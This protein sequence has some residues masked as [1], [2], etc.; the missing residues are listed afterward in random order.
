MRGDYSYYTID[1]ETDSIGGG[2]IIGGLYDLKNK[3][4]IYYDNEQEYWD[5]IIEL[6]LKRVKIFGHY[7]GRYDYQYLVNYLIKYRKDVKF[8]IIYNSK[9]IFIKMNN[10]FLYDTYNVFLTSLAKLEKAFNIERL[11]S[12]ETAKKMS[13]DYYKENKEQVI[14]YL[15]EDCINLANIILKFEE[16]VGSKIKATI[17]SQAMSYYYEHYKQIL[18]SSDTPTKQFLRKGYFG[19]RT[20]VFKRYGKNLFYYDINSSYPYIMRNFQMPVGGAMIV[21]EYID[22]AIGFYDI[23]VTNYNVKLPYIA[24]KY[25]NKLIYPL[26]TFQAYVTNLEI[27]ELIKD[28]QDFKVVRGIVYRHIKNIFRDY[29]DYF[30]QMKQ[31]AKA[32]DNKILYLISKL[33]MNSLYGKFAER[34][35]KEVIKNLKFEEVKKLLEKEIKVKSF[36]S[37]LG[38]YAVEEVIKSD[39]IHIQISSF[40]TAMARFRLYKF[41]K[42]LID[43]GY[44]VYYCDTDSIVTNANQQQMQEL[45]IP[46]HDSD[47][48]A[49][50][51]EH[52]INEG[53]FLLP[54]FYFIDN[55]DGEESKSKGFVNNFDKEL[56][57]DY[58]FNNVNK[59]DEN[60][61]KMIGFK[62]GLKRFGTCVMNVEGIK[63]V[64][65]DYDKRQLENNNIDTIPLVINEFETDNSYKYKAQS[66]KEKRKEIQLSLKLAID[67]LINPNL[68]SKIDY[69]QYVGTNLDLKLDDLPF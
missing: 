64:V 18:E 50:K 25:N 7:A 3:R 33:F 45:G 41:M 48:G 21:D 51:L 31:E 43:N 32:N 10:A 56:F 53:Y 67:S 36:R 6:T 19:G 28:K 29:I 60:V 61:R 4:F 24:K 62:D 22:N 39:K 46:I 30:Y 59:F 55:E 66:K 69:S 13:F 20:E 57:N 68:E 42:K 16:Y 23:V 2:F 63:N 49:L 11:E 1:I 9:I 35:E 34:E 58:L 14:A 47:L 40:I 37:D 38:L 15:K 17:A 12:K 8:S 27:H 65:N 54:K 44:E 5:K 26:G 52:K